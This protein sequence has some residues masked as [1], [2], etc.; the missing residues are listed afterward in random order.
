[1]ITRFTLVL[2]TVAG[3]RAARLSLLGC[4][5][6]TAAAAQTPTAPAPADTARLSYGEE[7]M[8][9]P[10]G[11]PVNGQPQG[12]YSKLAR[13]QIEE[14]ELF[15]LGLNNFSLGGY[16]SRYGVHLAYER[17]VATAW[18]VLGEI[19]PDVFRY[20]LGPTDEETHTK[21]AA[22]LQVAGRYYYNLNQRIRK[23]KSASNFSA[24][25]LSLGVG[26]G[27]GRYS[28]LSPYFTYGEAGKAVRAVAALHYGLQRR[29]GRY[30]F[31]DFNVG[32]PFLLTPDETTQD[33]TISLRIDM[34]LRIG[35]ALGR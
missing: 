24:N 13:L 2:R 7:T 27:L 31:V 18:S 30:G 15:K 6:S 1:M 35:L 19:S 16:E 4:L 11:P 23:G 25:Y 5:L 3:R 17:K 12:A 29:L 14:Q 22:R 32:I 21:L 34:N 26:A 9:E 20:R 33:N 8:P 28:T 10:L